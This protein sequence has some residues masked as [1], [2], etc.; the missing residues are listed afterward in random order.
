MKSRTPNVSQKQPV[1]EQ[2][3]QETR[4]GGSKLPQT[5]PSRYF[6]ECVVCYNIIYGER[7]GK[8][9]R[10]R[11]HKSINGIWVPW[12]GKHGFAHSPTCSMK[13]VTQ[14]TPDNKKAAAN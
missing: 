13:A 11:K 10:D 4:C 2:P 14:N 9:I 8:Y 5:M 7:Y 12:N 1:C 3:K 6:T